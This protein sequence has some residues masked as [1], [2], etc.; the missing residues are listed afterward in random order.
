MRLVKRSTIVFK[1]IQPRN[2]C[3]YLSRHQGVILLDVRTKEE[4]EGK[5]GTDFGTLKNAINV[6]IQE[7]EASLTGMDSLKGR[8][9][10][11][12]CSHSHRSPQASYILS[13]NGFVN[14]TNMAG[15]MSQVKD[16][17]CVK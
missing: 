15:G 9:I 6:P 3:N 14:V 16:A 17:P 7:L 2:I 10:I 8:E 5:A 11:V 13:T 12:Y 1:T 4:F